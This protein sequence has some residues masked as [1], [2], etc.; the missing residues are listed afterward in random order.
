MEKLLTDYWFF[1]AALVSVVIWLARLEGKVNQNEKDISN[2][3]Y[4]NREEI[5]NITGK[6]DSMNDKLTDLCVSFA[7]LAGYV[8]R[9]KEEDK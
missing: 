8:R 4:E 6:L 2:L 7:D 5:K 1:L 9:L 3:Q